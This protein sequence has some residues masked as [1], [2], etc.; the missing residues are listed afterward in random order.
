MP[1]IC[2]SKG[3]MSRS[4]DVKI[5]LAKMVVANRAPAGS[6]ASGGSGAHCKEQ[7]IGLRI[8]KPKLLSAPM[9][10]G[11]IVSLM[12][13]VGSVSASL[14][15][16]AAFCCNDYERS[17]AGTFF[18]RHIGCFA[19]QLPIIVFMNRCRTRLVE[20]VGTTSCI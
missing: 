7:T 20:A 16:I 14:S 8:I 18:S 9:I 5:I 12:S 2:S 3:Q 15:L 11:R 10:L 4:L 17:V 6:G 1:I 19:M 13:T